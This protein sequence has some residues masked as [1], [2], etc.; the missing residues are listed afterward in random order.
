MTPAQEAAPTISGSSDVVWVPGRAESKTRR[1]IP[2]A[3]DRP[4]AGQEA[5]PRSHNP[6]REVGTLLA[7]SR[8]RQSASTTQE[9]LDEHRYRRAR[10]QVRQ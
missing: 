5:A 3:C 1:P 8:N 10:H 7:T 4:A 2:T 9:P 6:P